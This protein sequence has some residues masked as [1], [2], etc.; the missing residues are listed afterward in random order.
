MFSWDSYSEI[1]ILTPDTTLFISTT[2]VLH[3]KVIKLDY[4]SIPIVNVE[5]DIPGDR[6]RRRIT[7]I[8]CKKCI[9]Q[10]EK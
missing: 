10:M 5:F 7:E 1:I 6:V 4:F 9:A 8:T 3:D 2:G